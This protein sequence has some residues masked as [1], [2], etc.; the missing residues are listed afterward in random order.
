MDDI[1]FLQTRVAELE[2]EVA[3][4]EDKIREVDELI[5]NKNNCLKDLQYDLQQIIKI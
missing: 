2:A 5:E 4:L 1:T 3:S